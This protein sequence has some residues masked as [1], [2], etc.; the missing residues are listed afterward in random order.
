MLFDGI[1][2]VLSPE[3][4]GQGKL[5]VFILLPKD[6]IRGEGFCDAQ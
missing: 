5:A 6:A 2:H 3:G 1:V 4:G